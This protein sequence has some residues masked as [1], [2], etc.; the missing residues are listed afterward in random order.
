MRCLLNLDQRDRF[1]GEVRDAG[2]LP[3]GED[4]DLVGANL[5]DEPS[6]AILLIGANQDGAFDKHTLSA[7]EVLGASF[8]EFSPRNDEVVVGDLPLH[9][10]G[11]HFTVRRE[12]KGDAGLAAF[13]LR[14][15]GVPG[16]MANRKEFVQALHAA[17]G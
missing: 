17:W 15:L 12:R 16:Q 7:T 5:R 8:A 14:L 6:L 11:C 9:V 13:C 10:I 2:A 3:P 4:I 1:D